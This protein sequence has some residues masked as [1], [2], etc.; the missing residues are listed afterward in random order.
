MGCVLEQVLAARCIHGHVSVPAQ[1][2]GCEICGAHGSELATTQFAALGSV[3][4]RARNAADGSWVATVALADGPAIRAW[5]ADPAAEPGETVHG[6]WRDGRL[7][8]AG[9]A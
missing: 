3:V 6:T 7:M 9:T 5:L 8:F 4:D 2:F 1:M